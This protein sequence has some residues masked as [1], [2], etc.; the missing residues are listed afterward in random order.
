MT[1]NKEFAHFCRVFCAPP[2]ECFDAWDTL[3]ASF[4]GVW[5][6]VELRMN[7]TE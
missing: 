5:A 3:S 7:V 2:H 6:F 1:K 4:A